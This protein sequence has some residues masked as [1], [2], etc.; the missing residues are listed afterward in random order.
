MANC[1]FNSVFDNEMF[2]HTCEVCGDVRYSDTPN[3]YK[4]C[5]KP[6]DAILST[7]QNLAAMNC[8]HR[9]GSIGTVPCPTCTGTVNIKLFVC[10]LLNNQK[11]A[12]SDK[13]ISAD[14]LDCTTCP[15]RAAPQLDQP[16]QPAA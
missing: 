9:T 8:R 5:G 6:A 11:C 16:P 12:L 13:L 2:A 10:S 4:R 7:D 3:Y 14:V 15:H 1:K